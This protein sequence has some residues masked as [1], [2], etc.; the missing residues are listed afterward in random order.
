MAAPS[1]RLLKVDL[2]TGAIT[3]Q[4]LPHEWRADYIGLRG[5]GTRLLSEL[6]A[7]EADPFGPENP[8]LFI[9]GPLTGTNAPTGGRYGVMT[10]G[11]LTGT[12]ACSN[13]GGHFGPALR[14]AGY[15]ALLFTGASEK[16]VYLFI[17]DDRV[18]LRDATDLWGES[19]WTVEERLKERHGH[20]V[21]IAGIGRAGENRV[22]YAA[23]MNDRDRAAGRTGVGAVMGAKK[24][25]AVVVRGTGAVELARPEEFATLAADLNQRIMDMSGM[26]GLAHDGT[27]A[28][29]RVT[30]SFG[31][32]PTENAR[33]TSF[34][35]CE[36]IS[37]EAMQRPPAPGRKPNLV[38]RKACFA[39]PIGCGRIAQIQPDHFTLKYG[40]Q[41]RGPNGGLEYEAAYALGAMVGVG[42][43]DACT[44]AFQVCN[45]EGMD[46]ISFG[47]TLAAA[48]ELFDLGALTEADTGRPLR[49][50]DAGALAEM[51]LATARREGFGDVLAEGALRL[52]TR[53]GHPAL[54]MQVKGQEF[55][56][57]D[58]RAMQGMGLAY[59][60]SPRGA[61]HLRASPYRSDFSTGDPKAKPK[62]VK[63]TQ[64]SK[65]AIDSL[66]V[67]SFITPQVDLQTLAELAAHATGIHYS[68]AHLLRAGERIFNL[69]RLFNLRAGFTGADDTLPDRVLT[70]PADAGVH[71]G[72][73]CHLDEM[74]PAY[75]R[76]REWTESGEPTPALLSRLGLSDLVQGLSP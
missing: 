30:C 3:R 41:Y 28:M 75:Y 4:E 29:M 14:F 56:G 2:A 66:G 43:L 36:N 20:D 39:C 16:P 21:R 23:V 72:E 71:K 19:F 62:V 26:R 37:A 63:Q 18:E 58:P 35:G 17:D 46:P 40:D 54:A 34:A 11:P 50:G 59:A 49:F 45:E 69:E 33:H 68:Q 31:A 9:T 13:A 32:L 38:G 47:V 1:F 70:E 42:D 12:I 7:F 52:C 6:R 44:F 27:Q 67:C 5:L 74:L 64:D 73:V 57:Y 60:T 10:R 24:L 25:K 48:M 53:H 51:A 65:A 76:L 22:R 15:D 8:L 55:P 61:C